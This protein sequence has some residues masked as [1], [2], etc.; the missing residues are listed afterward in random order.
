[1]CRFCF[2][3]PTYFNLEKYSDE[4]TQSYNKFNNLEDWFKGFVKPTIENIYKILKSNCYY[5]VTLW[6]CRWKSFK[7]NK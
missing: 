4:P 7:W 2:S 1:M 5:A 6:T 3:S